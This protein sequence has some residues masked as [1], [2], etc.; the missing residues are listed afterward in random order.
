MLSKPRKNV[1]LVAL[2]RVSDA[3]SLLSLHYFSLVLHVFVADDSKVRLVFSL[4]S[5]YWYSNI[6]THLFFVVLREETY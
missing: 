1:A 3:N 2:Q 5:K 4:N 6:N